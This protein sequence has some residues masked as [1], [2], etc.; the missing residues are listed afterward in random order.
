M[1]WLSENWGDLVTAFAAL[2][3]VALFVANLTPTP[4]D[5]ALIGKIYSG[6]MLVAG[7]VTK[8]AQGTK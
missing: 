3:V 7:L 5:N 8:E 2:H 6:V 1:N 4:K